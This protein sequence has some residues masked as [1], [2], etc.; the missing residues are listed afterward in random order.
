MC[1]LR[2]GRC[3]PAA[4]PPVPAAASQR[5]RRAPAAH[6]VSMRRRAGC[7]PRSCGHPTVRHAVP[8]SAAPRLAPRPRRVAARSRRRG[9]HHRGCRRRL[10]RSTGQRSHRLYRCRRPSVPLGAGRRRTPRQPCRHARQHDAETSDRRNRALRRGGHAPP[11]RFDRSRGQNHRWR[12]AL[13]PDVEP[14]HSPAGRHQR[15]ECGRRSDLRARRHRSR[16][17]LRAARRSDPRKARGRRLHSTGGQIHPGPRRSGPP[18]TRRGGPRS[19]RDRPRTGGRSRRA[20]AIRRGRPDQQHPDARRHR[21]LTIHRGR[22]R[23]SR[24]RPRRGGRSRRAPAIRRGRP[25]Q[26][27]PGARGRRSADDPP[28]LPVVG[29][30]SAPRR[31]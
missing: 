7:H 6:P 18:T 9:A 10:G 20:P 22:P 1:E 16:R 5:R 30:R 29:S 23:S 15:H 24:G 26:R 25:D 2:E 4:P 3:R 19:S 13:R 31:P 21:Q 8:R 28:R 27:H 14:G 17:A 11:D 12:T